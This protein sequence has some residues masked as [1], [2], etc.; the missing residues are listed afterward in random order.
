MNILL[1]HLSEAV[2][3]LHNEPLSN[4]RSLI[5]EYQIYHKPKWLSDDSY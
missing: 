3:V 4:A 2:T 5:K 1:S